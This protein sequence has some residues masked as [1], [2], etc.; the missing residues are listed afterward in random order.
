[1]VILEKEA[2]DR[3]YWENRSTSKMMKNLKT[4]EI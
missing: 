2:T 4:S 1:M 3:N